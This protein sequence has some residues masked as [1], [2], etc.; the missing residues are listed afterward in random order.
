MVK[1]RS[2]WDARPGWEGAFPPI[3]EL[4]PEPGGRSW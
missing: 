1:N 3:A 4:A 2:E